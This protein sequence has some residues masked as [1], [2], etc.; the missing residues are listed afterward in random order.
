MKARIIRDHNIRKFFE[1]YPKYRTTNI[2]YYSPQKFWNIFENEIGYVDYWDW[3]YGP[4]VYAE[5]FYI[6]QGESFQVLPHFYKYGSASGA[7]EAGVEGEIDALRNLLKD[8]KGICIYIYYRKE[9]GGERYERELI[10]TYIGG[11]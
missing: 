11:G 3:A 8:Y 5:L 1:Q 10:Y 6:K 9:R 2:R 4:E 7:A